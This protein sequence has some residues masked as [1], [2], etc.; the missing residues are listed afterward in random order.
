MDT[1]VMTFNTSVGA[2]DNITM[3]TNCTGL[4]EFYLEVVGG[5]GLCGDG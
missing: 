1:F 4:N 3:L 2:I 5:Q